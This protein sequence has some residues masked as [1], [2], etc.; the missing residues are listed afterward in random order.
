ME[1]GQTNELI[2]GLFTLGGV[3]LGSGM[4]FLGQYLLDKRRIQG[5]LHALYEE[6]N[7]FWKQLKGEVDPYWKMFE[8]GAVKHFDCRLSLS[9]DYITIYRSNANFIGQIGDLELRHKIVEVYMLL[10][11]LMQ[12]YAI[13]T[14]FLY[15]YLEVK[16]RHEEVVAKREDAVAK[17]DEVEANKNAIEANGIKILVENSMRQLRIYAPQLKKE[18]DD[19]AKLVEKLLKML[20][21]KLPQQKPAILYGFTKDS[22]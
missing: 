12:G 16:D 7:S 19:F 6:L 10:Q 22:K 4:T 18:H 11:A 3:I 2:T 8:R 17:R 9:P 14:K 1:C 15:E 20:K 21:E 5:V 13:N